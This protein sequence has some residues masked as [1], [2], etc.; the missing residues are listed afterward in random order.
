MRI[1][2]PT[3]DRPPSVALNILCCFLPVIIPA[4]QLASLGFIY[5]RSGSRAAGNGDIVANWAFGILYYVVAQ[6]LIGLIVAAAIVYH[7]R[8]A[9][10]RSAANW[11][12]RGSV[13]VPF[14]L[15]LLGA[16][17]ITLFSH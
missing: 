8:T 13:L 2:P 4:A 5:A 17:A 9:R 11:Y 12:L 1:E 6:Y 16:L 3:P 14:G 15:L 10:L 7:A